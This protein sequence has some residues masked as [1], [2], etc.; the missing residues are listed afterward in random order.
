MAEAYV[1]HDEVWNELIEGKIVAMSPRPVVN[2]SF[3]AS[4]IFTIF[5]VYLKGKKCVPF[6]DGVDLLLTP[7]DRFIPDCMVVCDRNKI[8]FDGVHGAPDLVVE[9][10]SPSTAKRDRGYKKDVYAKCGVLEYWIVSPGDMSIEVY[11]SKD[12]ELVYHDTYT[13]F[14][15]YLLEKMT[16]EE[17]AGVEK[18][19]K[20]SLFDDLEISLDDIFGDLI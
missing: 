18:A 7:K 17:R 19:F 2:H 5:A 20:C 8:K 16:D 4:N 11:R 1:Y 6:S 13:F 10:L 15:D 14:P 9:V 3:I 12:N